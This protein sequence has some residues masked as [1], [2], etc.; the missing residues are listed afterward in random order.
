L[1]LKF[2]NINEALKLCSDI[3]IEEIGTIDFKYYR[4]FSSR[5][6]GYCQNEDLKTYWPSRKPFNELKSIFKYASHNDVQNKV[7]NILDTELDIFKSLREAFFPKH[8][9]FY[10]MKNV[11]G[12]SK[13]PGVSIEQ[14]YSTGFVSLLMTAGNKGKNTLFYIDDKDVEMQERSFIEVKFKSKEHAIS[15]DRQNRD[16]IRN[17]VDSLQCL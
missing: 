2:N 4:N 6:W 12:P 3:P 13:I 9:E 15:E 16:E 8:R 5:E 17:A 14:L 10:K 7:K 11:N 1:V